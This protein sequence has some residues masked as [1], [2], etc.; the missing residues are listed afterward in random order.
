[1]LPDAR[2][3]ER[4]SPVCALCWALLGS[5]SDGTRTRDLRRDRG[6]LGVAD[7]S[8]GAVA[9]FAGTGLWQLRGRSWTCGHVVGGTRTD[10]WVAG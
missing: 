2:P 3:L 10:R 6:S 1:M 9:R 5:G 4:E 8:F 7:A